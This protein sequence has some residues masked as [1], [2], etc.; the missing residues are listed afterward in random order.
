MRKE[1]IWAIVAGIALGLVV[2]FGVWRINSTVTSNKKVV[3]VQVTPSPTPQ[4]PTEFKIVIDKPNSNDVF[5]E[6]V[7][8]VSGV[9]KPNLWVTISGQEDDYITQSDATGAFAQEVGLDSGL[10]QLKITAVDE[11]GKQTSEKVNVIYSS[12]FEPRVPATSPPGSTSTE[13]SEIRQKVAEDLANT[14]NRPKAYI[15]VVTDITESTIEIKTTTS[16][17]QQISVSETTA[18]VV[19]MVGTTD[20]QVKPTDIAIGDFIVVMGYVGSNSVLGAQRIL[21]TEPFVDNKINVSLAKVV[22]TTKKTI[23]VTNLSDSTEGVLTPDSKSVLKSFKEGEISSLKLT[24][25]LAD[26]KILYFSTTDAKGV[27]QIR[28][29]FVIP[30]N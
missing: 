23:N 19:N 11:T 9:T 20:K 21:I 8:T 12:S 10:N 2:A 16:D 3:E 29:L 27:T 28:T 22:S 13:S 17:I 18:S 26:D 30:Q 15:G 7:V 1:V 25:I 4:G 6:E 5:T 14:L 24:G